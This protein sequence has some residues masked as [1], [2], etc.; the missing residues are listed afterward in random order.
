MTV[1]LDHVADLASQLPQSDQLR[2]VERIA[3]E[4]AAGSPPEPPSE[5]RRWQD[6]RGLVA[7]PYVAKDVQTWVSQSRHEA[8]EQREKQHRGVP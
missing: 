1:S 6:I 3:R 4:L 7:H 2:L 5:P 8:D